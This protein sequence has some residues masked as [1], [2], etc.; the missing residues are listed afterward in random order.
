MRKGCSNEAAETL[1]STKFMNMRAHSAVS[2]LMGAFSKNRAAGCALHKIEYWTSSNVVCEEAFAHMF[3]AQFDEIR[4]NKM[5]RYFP[6]ALAYF[7]E[8]LEVISRN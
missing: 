7:E 2:D 8:K 3:E 1:A 4:Y 5:K 6:S